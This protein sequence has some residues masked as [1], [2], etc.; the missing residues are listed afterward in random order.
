MPAG[1]P[2]GFFVSPKSRF[3]AINSVHSLSPVLSTFASRI[4]FAKDMN[5]LLEL[6]TTKLWMI[7]P[8]YVHGSRAIW[9]QNLNGRIALD[10]Q[11][12]KK[13]YA[14][15][16]QDGQ[17]V[18]VINEYQVTENGKT[19][20]RWW[21][22]EMDAPFVN[23][24]PVDGP[25]TREGGACSYG[26]MDL[27]DWMMEAA[28]NEFCK[29]H[30]FV[31]N[32]PGGS[33]WAINDFKQAIDYA[34]E[35]GQKV[36]AFVDGLCASAAMYLASVCDEVYF[37][38]PKDMFG[39]IGVM[40]AFYTEKN[41][42]TNQYTNETYHELYDPESYDK[43]KWYRDIA[44][45]SKNDKKLMDDL[46]KTGV[47]FRA[48]IQKSFPAATEKHI[49]GAL[50]EAQEV[51]GILCDGQM[52]LGEVVARA[53]EVAN[54]SA[55]PIERVAPVKPEDDVPEDDPAPAA[56]AKTTTTEA[57]ASGEKNNPLNKENMK[58]YEKIAT[59]CGVEELIVNEEGA[60]FVPSMLD[61]LNQTLE[62]QA[63]DKAAADEQVQTLQTQ[64]SEAEN[65]KTEAVNAKEQELN[66]SHEKAMGELKTAHEQE[67]NNMKQQHEE[68]LNAEKEAKGKVEQ[69]LA[70][71]KESLATAEQQ[72]KEREA[73]IETLKGKPGDQQEGSPANNG[74]GAES[75]EATCGM[76][77][78]D[79]N[80]TPLENA[81][82]RKE[83]MESLQK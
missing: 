71:V 27:R 59:A 52:T 11:Q 49:H 15:Q 75:H 5:G 77:D 19:T 45:N 70:E 46:K 16:I 22:D 60:H 56:S 10:L 38:H 14:M 83:Y 4:K 68:Q 67:I 72:L 31:I 41:G 34:H 50:F 81:R 79:H 48:D 25:I 33:A 12:K 61:A 24:M 62:Q 21:M 13:P 53:F 73:Q 26:S 29:A 28:N 57:S 76:P 18:G 23:V 64:L 3:T 17:A 1:F 37:M 39:S 69:E 7:M 74:T 30:I 44:E 63:S 9:E 55:T 65:A 58:Q 82:I 6:L 36:Y 35:H 8:E 54:G 47:E 40:A 80:K 51:T 2:S 43:N 66:D 78:Y 42:T 32:S 20:S